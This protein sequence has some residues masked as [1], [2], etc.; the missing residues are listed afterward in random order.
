M[1]ETKGRARYPEDVMLKVGKLFDEGGNAVA[2][3]MEYGVKDKT[4]YN[5][6]LKYL[7]HKRSAAAKK[8][9]AKRQT[10]NKSPNGKSPSVQDL[11]SADLETE[12]QRLRAE[13]SKRLL[14][15]FLK[16]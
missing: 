5:W 10:V 8:G 1:A 9:T 6:R 12:N 14:E 7:K 15:D 2:L 4:I 11:R 16:A 13:L 3:A